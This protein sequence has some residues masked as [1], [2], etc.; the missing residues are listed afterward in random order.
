M[1]PGMWAILIGHLSHN[2]TVE[3]GWQ[4][5]GF[6]LP[7]SPHFPFPLFSPFY[8]NLSLLFL[9]RPSPSPGE[10]HQAAGCCVRK[11]CD[12]AITH[13]HWSSFSTQ[14]L[15]GTDLC[16]NHIMWL[17]WGDCYLMQRQ[18]A[19]CL[20]PSLVS[21]TQ[22]GRWQLHS[23]LDPSRSNMP[24]LHPV[25]FFSILGFAQGS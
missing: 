2:A 9:F 20:T 12:K 14:L 5:T 17:V 13:R 22:R 19:L 21:D 15:W 6:H 8:P 10:A 3:A 7:P 11:P 23:S 24:F 1:A 18:Q 4:S 25:K 16:H